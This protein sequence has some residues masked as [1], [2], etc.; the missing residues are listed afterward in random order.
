MSSHIQDCWKW[1]AKGANYFC[2]LNT[3]IWESEN[4]SWIMVFKWRVEVYIHSE[5]KWEARFLSFVVIEKLWLRNTQA[6][7][8]V[9]LITLV[10]LK[11]D[12]V[13][14]ETP[15][16]NKINIVFCG[17]SETA[18]K[19][20]VR[21]ILPFFLNNFS[22]FEKLFPSFLP[23]KDTVCIQNMNLT[24]FLF[25]LQEVFT[26]EN[27]VLK[28]ISRSQLTGELKIDTETHCVRKGNEL[29]NVR[30]NEYYW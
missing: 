15:F 23:S 11:V 4:V 19:P 27:G 8:L 24:I 13:R 18:Q 25:I 26:V 9:S 17:Y 12:P 10:L 5:T 2:H 6:L 14:Y 3:S 7:K 28:I 16:T 29:H 30:H 21:I 1:K 20:R 22:Q